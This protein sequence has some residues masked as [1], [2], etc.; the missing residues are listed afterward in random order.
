MPT[1]FPGRHHGHRVA[2]LAAQQSVSDGPGESRVSGGRHESC[3]G[4]LIVWWAGYGWLWLV[5]AD[6]GWLWLAC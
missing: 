6:Y 4:W 3:V 1:R 2:S 5:M